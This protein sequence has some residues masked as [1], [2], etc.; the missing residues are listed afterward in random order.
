MAGGMDMQMDLQ[1]N[2]L[3][4]N[5]AQEAFQGLLDLVVKLQS[6]I[7]DLGA[8]DI[9]GL[10]DQMQALAEMMQTTAEAA[11]K[12]QTAIEQAM[13]GSQE[14]TVSATGSATDLRGALEEVAATSLTPIMDS[15]GSVEEGAMGASDQAQ[16]LRDTLVEVADS[17]LT[18]AVTSIDGVTSALETANEQAATLLATLKLVAEEEIANGAGA[19]T[20]GAGTGAAGAGSGA[21]G[22]NKMTVGSLFQTGMYGLMGYMGLNMLSSSANLFS[23]M[24]AF[25]ADNPGMTPTDAERAMTELGAEGVTGTA[26]TSL[27]GTLGGKSMQSLFTLN[28]MLSRQGLQ[29]QSLGLTRQM[30]TASPWEN[31]QTIGTLYRRLSS[32][33]QGMNAMNLL[34]L[35]GTSGLQSMF[36]NWNT[37]QSQTSD[38]N[39]GMNATQ[40]AHFAATGQTMA[41]DMQKLAFA[42]SEM[43]VELVP[44]IQPLVTGFSDLMN[45]FTGRMSPGAA[46][47]DLDANLSKAQQAIL[48]FAMGLAAIKII[49]LIRGWF[50]ASATMTVTA[51]TVIVNGAIGTGTTGLPGGTPATTTEET[52][53]TTLANDEALVGTDALAAAGGVGALD[54]AVVPI[55]APLL[56][57]AAAILL[58][59]KNLGKTTPEAIN[60]SHAFRTLGVPIYDTIPSVTRLTDG[61][62]NL[63]KGMGTT[64]TSTEKLGGATLHLGA[65]MLSA[66][67]GIN[68]W[69]TQLGNAID[70]A[71]ASVFPSV[72]SWGKQLSAWFAGIMHSLGLGPAPTSSGGTTQSGQST[73]GTIAQLN[74]EIASLSAS[75]EQYQTAHPGSNMNNNAQLASYHQRADALRTQLAALEQV[76]SHVQ[77]MGGQQQGT[78]ASNTSNWVQ[79][80][81]STF[82]SSISPAWGPIMNMLAGAESGG[83]PTKVSKT[84]AYYSP[85]YGTQYAQGI[86]QMMAPTYAEYG[87]VPGGILNPVDNIQASMNYIL[88][89]YKTPAAFMADTGLGTSSYRGYAAGGPINEPVIGLGMMSGAPYMFGES[90]PESVSPAGR[91]GGAQSL[92]LSVNVTGQGASQQ[93]LARLVA[94][95]IVMALKTRANV[96]IS[97]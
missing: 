58:I 52:A 13:T 43:A 38:I 69:G 92:N 21:T 83:N 70:A 31:L 25:M 49:N 84:G 28:G 96:D 65:D 87:G 50:H 19:G 15:L 16:A 5:D 29:L 82:G 62:A 80:A 45:V 23:T 88:S 46:L 32:E 34:S 85:K 42:F 76:S 56:A 67:K 75:F 61:M 59:S 33:G 27:M 39:A 41:V 24:Q 66:L 10:L 63:H 47:Q 72:V 79:Q 17:S 91:S 55:A 35:T 86:M 94:Q 54:L 53:A 97:F 9:Q 93:E 2:L 71:L 40:L 78:S 3:A 48:G 60:A 81:L 1:F 4:E 57:M 8:T 44:L 95:E 6:S 7:E 36:A 26:A 30:M 68:P 22:G 37:L 89:R 11:A 18:G 90:G 12:V 64:T 74:Q 14:A 51:G 20:A 77:N 73:T